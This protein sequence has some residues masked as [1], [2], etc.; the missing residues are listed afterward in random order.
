MGQGDPVLPEQRPLAPHAVVKVSASQAGSRAVLSPMELPT[1]WSDKDWARL[2]ST[3]TPATTATPF[4]N[5]PSAKRG[6]AAQAPP[7]L[8][9]GA[10]E[11]IRAAVNEAPR[12]AANTPVATWTQYTA[13]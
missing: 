9:Q 10:Q 5:M 8:P 7:L 1:T 4:W 13:D 12:A 3:W 6:M 11:P 2:G